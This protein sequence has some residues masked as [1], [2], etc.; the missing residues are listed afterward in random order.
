MSTEYRNNHY[1]PVW[2]QN[3]FIPQEQRDKDLLYLD[4]NPKVGRTPQG[5][6]YKI[7]ELQRLGPKHCFFEADLY[8][9]WFGEEI[10]TD[11]E[12]IFFGD[13]D[14][15]GREGIDA[16]ENFIHGATSGNEFHKLI[17]F[18]SSQKLRT[19]KGLEWLRRQANNRTHH[20]TLI[21]MIQ[22]HK[23][24]CAIWT[25]C[26][27]QI[28]DAQHSPTKF[29]ISDH[30]VT[31]YNRVLGPRSDSCKGFNDPDIRQ[32]ASHTLFPLSENK[33]LI[34]TNLSWARDPYQNEKKFRPN[35]NFHRD[36]VFSMLDVQ[37]GRML[38]EK[39]VQQINFI[40]KSRALR[41]I[42]ASKKEW[43][44]PENFVSKSD[45][46]RYGDGYLLMPDPRSI[47][48]NG[49]VAFLMR[50]GQSE[51]FDEYGRRS[52]QKGYDENSANRDWS[53]L[54]KFQGEFARLFG[55]KRR[56]RSHQY[57]SLSDE[58]DPDWIHK[59]N[60]SLEKGAQRT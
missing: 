20:E 27:W 45:W 31:I 14:R 19:P 1:V 44:Y 11:I 17:E 38:N 24:F 15:K 39:E 5:R 6:S 46:S 58:E 52:W 47:S 30:P 13:I 4:L 16:F 35:P 21:L 23:M 12:K 51:S 29:I 9:R 41:Y 28:A 40:I 43:L 25:E 22:L 48:R 10:V 34:L 54:D 3:R 49:V 55:P 8:T 57:G 26:V 18:L 53:S 33:I 37:V 36:A 32:N 60:L 59:Y 7:K 50:N 56:G 2:Y 42:A